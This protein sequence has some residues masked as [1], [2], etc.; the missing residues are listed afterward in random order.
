MDAVEPRK[1]S[2]GREYGAGERDTVS[3]CASFVITSAGVAMRHPNVSP[4]KI[5]RSVGNVVES[6]SL[7]A[8]WRIDLSATL[9]F[10]TNMRTRASPWLRRQRLRACRIKRRVA[11]RMH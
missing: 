2:Y 7:V 8:V 3:I 10:F 4:L 6:L 11:L 1:W 9:G 5:E